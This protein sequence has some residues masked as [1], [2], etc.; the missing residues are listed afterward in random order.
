M[1]KPNVNREGLNGSTG[2]EERYVGTRSFQPRDG[3][4]AVVGLIKANSEVDDGHAATHQSSRLNMKSWASESF[5]DSTHGKLRVD[6]I[7]SDAGRSRL[8][9][10]R[11]RR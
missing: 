10:A 5:A 3:L 4:S 6:R 2:S 11:A 8:G 7:N 9:E 1:S